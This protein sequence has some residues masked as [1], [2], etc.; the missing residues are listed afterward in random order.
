MNGLNSPTKTKISSM[1]L[2][3]QDP[4]ICGICEIHLNQNNSDGLRIKAWAK[5]YQANGNNK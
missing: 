1:S 2:I 5:K 4:S 3:K